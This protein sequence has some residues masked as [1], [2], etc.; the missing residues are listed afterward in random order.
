MLLCGLQTFERKCDLRVIE[1]LG[2]L[3]IPSVLAG[4]YIACVWSSAGLRA[5][6]LHMYYPEQAHGRNNLR[7]LGAG[8][9]AYIARAWRGRTNVAGADGR[10]SIDRVANKIKSS[11]K[12]TSNTRA[13]IL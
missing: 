5:R 7:A 10:C 2:S 9:R 12:T 6:T 3:I 1:I 8:T 4:A 13:L 11:T